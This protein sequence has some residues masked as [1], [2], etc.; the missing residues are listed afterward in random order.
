MTD[1][2]SVTEYVCNATVC[3]FDVLRYGGESHVPPGVHRNICLLLHQRESEGMMR[4]TH[5][6]RQND[7]DRQRQCLCVKSED[8]TVCHRFCHCVLRSNMCN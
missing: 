2:M 6:E 4:E 7:T 3:G 5:I 8:V 1:C